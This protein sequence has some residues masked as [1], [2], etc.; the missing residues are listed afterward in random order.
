MPERDEDGKV[1]TGPFFKATNPMK[2]GHLDKALFMRPSYIA[3]GD[4]FKAA[5]IGMTRTTKKDG[6]LAAGHDKAF[7]PAKISMGETANKCNVHGVKPSYD[8][9]PI[10][11]GPKKNFRD[12]E[13]TVITAPANMKVNKIKVGKVGKNVTIA[14]IIPYMEDD[15]DAKKKLAR[16]ELERHNALV[17]EKPFS[18]KA[19]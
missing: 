13:G 9:M 3:T 8:Y 16:K 4:P 19:K 18:Q 11:P 10:G 15:Y 17:Q 7:K 2:K 12:E 6:H 1:V 14:G 5:A